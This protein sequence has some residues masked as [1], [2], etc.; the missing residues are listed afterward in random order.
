MIES[1]LQGGTLLSYLLNNMIAL[2]IDLFFGT[3]SRCRGIQ[4]GW[5]IN[6]VHWRNFNKQ[7][8]CKDVGSF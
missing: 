8:I 2:E 7:M 4:I 5:H 6:R 3:L 1:I